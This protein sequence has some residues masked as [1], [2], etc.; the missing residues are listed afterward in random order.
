MTVTLYLPLAP[1]SDCQNYR[2]LLIN[3]AK[4]IYYFLP[5]LP[6][7]LKGA[8]R[9]ISAITLA[10]FLALL[11]PSS[12]ARSSSSAQRK[13]TIPP[14]QLFCLANFMKSPRTGQLLK[15]NSKIGQQK[16]S[17]VLGLFYYEL[18]GSKCLCF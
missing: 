17:P 14:W 3:H 5:C 11:L 18:I 9:I 16:S 6:R 10:P 15:C 4:R 7:N 2:Q 1:Y 13:P 12:M 8:E